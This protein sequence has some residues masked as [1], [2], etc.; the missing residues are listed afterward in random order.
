MALVTI[1]DPA[2]ENVSYYSL[3]NKRAK[4]HIIRVWAYDSTGLPGSPTLSQVQY[5]LDKMHAFIGKNADVGVACMAGISR[6]SAV[7]L[8][9]LCAE[10]GSVSEAMRIWKTD[11]RASE[12]WPNNAIILYADWLL[13]LNGEL[14]EAVEDYKDELQ[15]P[16]YIK[17]RMQATKRIND[18]LEVDRCARLNP[19]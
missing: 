3:P 5:I 8:M 9:L 14:V 19:M 2:L 4:Q 7:A 18:W 17:R 16:L 15:Y 1:L 13:D 6:S 11:P 10:N 12:F